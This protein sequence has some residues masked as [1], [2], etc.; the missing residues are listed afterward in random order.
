MGTCK[1]LAPGHRRARRQRHRRAKIGKCDVDE[2]AELAAKFRIMS[3]PST[4]LFKNGQ[5]VDTLM[6]NQ[7]SP[8]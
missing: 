4:G 5:K 2:A 3:V 7:S 8:R 1:A 6:G